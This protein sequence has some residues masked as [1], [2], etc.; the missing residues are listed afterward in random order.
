M[1]TT[2][3][4]TAQG[5]LIPFSP[6]VSATGKASIQVDILESLAPNASELTEDSWLLN[7]WTE[8]EN[9][10]TITIV[11]EAIKQQFY[12]TFPFHPNQDVLKIWLQQ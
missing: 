6:E 9:R 5:Y 12:A 7:W 10:S 1:I 4:K 8:K 3:I 11:S 2:A